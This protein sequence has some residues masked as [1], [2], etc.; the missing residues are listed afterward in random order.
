M[1]LTLTG[2]GEGFNVGRVE[3]GRIV[4][5]FV[6]SLVTD[7]EGRSLVTRLDNLLSDLIVGFV[8]VGVLSVN[9]GVIEGRLLTLFRGRST[10]LCP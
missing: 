1:V 10:F 3:D 8:C 7:V 2:T 9:V 4:V 6:V 5:V